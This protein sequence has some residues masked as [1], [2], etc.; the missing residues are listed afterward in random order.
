MENQQAGVLP[1]L[2]EK[3]KMLIKGLFIGFMI[4]VMLIPVAMLMALV[5]ERQKRQQEVTS[6]ISSK[7]ASQQTVSGP[8]IAVPYIVKT[9]SAKGTTIR[10]YAYVLPEQ[11]NINGKLLPEIRHRSIYDVTLYRSFLNISGR[12]DPAAIQKLNIPAENILWNESTVMLGLDD[13]RG[14]EEEV[15]LQWNNTTASLEAGLPDNS[16]IKNGAECA[17]SNR[18][19]TKEQL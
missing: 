1:T 7:W 9:D 4:V 15:K 6:E 13:A 18:R 16:I 2:W 17:R 3:N 5:N 11:L 19:S 8:V 12:F 10:R 14:L